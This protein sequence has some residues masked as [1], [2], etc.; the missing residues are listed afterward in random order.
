M[1]EFNITKQNIKNTQEEIDRYT[2]N[3]SRQLFAKLNRD[4]D[5][6]SA[7]AT[8]HVDKA[9]DHPPPLI[10]I[11]PAPS[12]FLQHHPDSDMVF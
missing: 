9:A 1:K 10:P 12:I 3:N 8:F 11:S 6:L 7:G 4:F 5:S 2:E